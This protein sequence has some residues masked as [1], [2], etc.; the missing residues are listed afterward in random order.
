MFFCVLENCI[1]APDELNAVLGLTSMIRAKTF[2][3][4][5]CGHFSAD[6]PQPAGLASCVCFGRQQCSYFPLSSTTID[7]ES[8]DG[9]KYHHRNL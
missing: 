4:C 6:G 1:S 9:N 5:C 2:L 3:F 7:C 8:R